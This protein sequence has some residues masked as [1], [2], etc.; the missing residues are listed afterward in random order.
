[1]QG[2][3]FSEKSS[4]IMKKIIVPMILRLGIFNIFS[5]KINRRIAYK[6]SLTT[7]T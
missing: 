4:Y 1:M 7:F 3:G 6:L 2:S 5:I